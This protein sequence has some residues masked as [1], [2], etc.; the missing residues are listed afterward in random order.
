MQTKVGSDEFADLV[1]IP[2]RTAWRAEGASPFVQVDR[3]PSVVFRF[4]TPL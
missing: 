1:H 2:A 4:V 3:Y